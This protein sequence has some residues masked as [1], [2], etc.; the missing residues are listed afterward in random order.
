[1]SNKLPSSKKKDW[2]LGA[3]RL[4]G[5]ALI[6]STLF[7]FASFIYSFNF[8]YPLFSML[9]LFS[10]F[11]HVIS[12]FIA[13]LNSWF[14][15]KPK[16]FEV[17]SGHEPIVAVLIPTMGEPVS[18]VLKTIKSVLFQNYPQNKMVI[19]V[20]DDG[21]SEALKDKIL[22][23]KRKYSNVFYL[24]PPEKNS[25][26]R[27]GE[28][29]AGN[30]NYALAFVL[31]NFPGV[32]FIET[33]DADDLVG[34]PDFLRL[35]I[36]SLLADKKLNFVQTIKKAIVSDGDP[37]SNI[38]SLF[39]ERTMGYRNSVNAAFP[40]GSGLVWRMSSLLKIGAFPT[41]NLVEDL[42]SGYE[43]V[44]RGGRGE[45]LPI[46]GAV[47]QSA[48]EDIPNY[49]KQRGTWAIDS[50]R[51]FFWDNPIFA[52]KLSFWQRLQ[53]FELGYSYF[54]SFTLFV[55]IFSMWSCLTVSVCPIVSFSPT[56]L[57]SSIV[58]IVL[59]EVYNIFRSRG[60]SYGELWK[61]RQNWIGLLPVFTVSLIKTLVYGPFRKPEYKVTRKNQ[62]AGIYWKEIAVQYLLVLALTYALVNKL[63]NYS[64]LIFSD[65]VM[66]FWS[67][68]LIFGFSRVINNA[69]M[70]ISLG[71]IFGTLFSIKRFFRGITFE[72]K[73]LSINEAL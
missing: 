11:L 30:L 59:L 13:V 66:V 34:D 41:W 38:E 39:Y 43:A 62:V 1:M 3:T 65:I 29:K 48:P 36:G 21:K 53:F 24:T 60:V 14:Y 33:R 45:Y 9:F 22:K 57:I 71:Q 8:E 55:F 18:M 42:Y 46:V 63:L 15:A 16:F 68:F 51:L 32:E 12:I 56:F 40:C 10:F 17:K 49:Y 5:V 25:V 4:T 58:F 7:Q 44:R 20:S 67:L 72:K 54:I 73:S 61:T 26:F 27:L 50:L 28:A 64:T 6:L 47:A 37:F 69:F 19:I 70:G 23:V 35:A 2:L 52:K 31:N